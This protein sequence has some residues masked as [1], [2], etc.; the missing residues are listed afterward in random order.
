MVGRALKA[1]LTQDRHATDWVQTAAA[2]RSAWLAPSPEVV[3][4]DAVIVDLRSA[5]WQRPG[6]YT[7][8][9]CPQSQKCHPDRNGA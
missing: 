4:Y 7:P 8:G 9:S 6:P 3:P 1:G 2:A 5:R